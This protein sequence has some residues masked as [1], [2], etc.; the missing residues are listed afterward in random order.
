MDDSPKGP[1]WA[2]FTH[3]E[4]I[5][6]M[7]VCV[8]IC[9]GVHIL[10]AWGEVTNWGDHFAID[11]C[12]FRAGHP[13]GWSGSTTKLYT[14]LMID[15][16][17][18]AFFTCWG[19]LQRMKQV[20]LGLL[21]AVPPDAF[22]RGALAFLFPRGVSSYPI[23]SSLI[24]VSLVWGVLWYALSF[25]ILAVLWALPVAGRPGVSFCWSGTA[26]ITIR[27]IFSTLEAEFVVAG[28]FILWCSKV[29]DITW[30]NTGQMRQL[31]RQVHEAEAREGAFVF[32][33][34][35]PNLSLEGRIRPTGS[36]PCV[37]ASPHFSPRVRQASCS[38]SVS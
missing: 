37:L 18:T 32:G 16:S 4:C 7:I 20:Q 29:E 30:R 24:G 5:T 15:C 26:Y 27:S 12:L 2:A 36:L 11:E 17:L 19:Q 31:T 23:M 28:S 8:F 10:V 14:G 13:H 9:G 3:K 35:H 25:G 34:M 1:V 38:R 6:Q 21:P 22:H 33:A